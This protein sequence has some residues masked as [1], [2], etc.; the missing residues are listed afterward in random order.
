MEL[1]TLG[2]QA[3][4]AIRGQETGIASAI[5]VGDSFYMVD[6]GLGCT[7]AAHMAGLRGHRFRAGFITHLHSDHI[8]ELPGFLLWNWGQQV[9]GFTSSVRLLGPGPDGDQPDGLE[10]AGTEE[11]VGHLMRAFSYDLSIRTRDEGRPPLADLIDV[12]DIRIEPECA[13]TAAAGSFD[14]YEDDRVRVSAALVNHPPVQ[15]ALAFRFESEKGSVTFSGDT[16]ECEALALLARDTDILVH[17]AVNL[18]YYSS[19]GFNAEFINHHRQSHT[20][21]EGAGRIAKAAGAK[22]LVLSHLAGVAPAEYWRDS[23]ALAYDG[24]IHVACS[25][26]AYPVDR[27]RAM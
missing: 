5:V 27:T 21:P 26:D 11:M 18:D 1:I 17:E 8:I 9:D 6:F 14:V 22:K 7:R 24:E 3:G 10:K 13:S 15:P 23:A 12:S 25:G 2:T 19:R 16:A 4:P 20:T